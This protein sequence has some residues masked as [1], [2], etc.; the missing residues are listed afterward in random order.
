MSVLV[1]ELGSD[2]YN[3]TVGNHLKAKSSKEQA[4]QIWRYLSSFCPMRS[5]TSPNQ[6]L[7]YVYILKPHMSFSPPSQQRNQ[8]RL[9][10]WWP[11]SVPASDH[12]THNPQKKKNKKKNRCWDWWVTVVVETQDKRPMVFHVSCYRCPCLL[13]AATRRRS[14][15]P[16]EDP[17]RRD[18]LCFQFKLFGVLLVNFEFLFS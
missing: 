15:T 17:H 5:W 11:T 18:N 12:R 13:R 6:P 8:Q 16:A 9:P 10:S 2:P 3:T 1:S 4:S 7:Q 14:P